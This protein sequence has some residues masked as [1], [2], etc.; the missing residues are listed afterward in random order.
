MTNL[1]SFQFLAMI[2]RGLRLGLLLLLLFLLWTCVVNAI[3]PE[4]LHRARYERIAYRV[5]SIE[6]LFRDRQRYN[7]QIT[8]DIVYISRCKKVLKNISKMRTVS[9]SY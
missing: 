6:K 2:Q 9:V 7:R 5:T 1:I 3:T 8:E 4:E